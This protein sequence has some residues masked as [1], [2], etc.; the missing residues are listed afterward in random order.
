MINLSAD[1]VWDLNVLVLR[2][3]ISSSS[4]MIGYAVSLSNILLACLIELTKLT[5]L[6]YKLGHLSTVDCV[7]LD[8]MC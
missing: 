7:D 3:G 6:Q 1:L 2:D 4:F 8:E 5:K